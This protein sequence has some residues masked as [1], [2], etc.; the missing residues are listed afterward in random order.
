MRQE[1]IEWIDALKF[2]GIF[3]IYLGHM[4]PPAGKI[5][6]FVFAFHVALFFF[7]S[8]CFADSGKNKTISSFIAAKFR[9][10]MIPYFIYSA[11]S[12]CIYI[13]STPDSSEF[14]NLMGYLTDAALGV[15]NHTIYAPALWFLP[16]IFITSIIFRLL[17]SLSPKKYIIPLIILAYLTVNLYSFNFF[18]M[19][20]PALW[21]NID[22]ALYYIIFY[23][24]GWLSI[25]KI[26]TTNWAISSTNPIGI[27]IFLLL[28]TLCSV[29]FIKGIGYPLKTLD[30]PMPLIFRTLF[31]IGIVV[32]IIIFHFFIANAISG[33]PMVNTLGKDTLTLC[34]TE[35]ITKSILSASA[36]TIGLS[37]N[38]FNGF[39]AVVFTTAMLVFSYYA[40]LPIKNHITK[41]HALNKFGSQAKRPDTSVAS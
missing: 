16:C 4:G 24:L 7:I 28:S 27:V 33:I 36:T 10:L 20:Q 15:R 31:N 32:L 40:V 12:I 19:S 30:I 17:Q 25:D 11:I 23:C 34:G 8:G 18:P 13:L 26:K 21:L 14:T 3:Y 38:I 37:L 22:S 39:S 35:T 29:V 2:V 6:T 1:R 41:H 9:Q 5:F